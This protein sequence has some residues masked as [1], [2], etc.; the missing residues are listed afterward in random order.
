MRNRFVL[1]EVVRLDLSDGDWIE[2]KKRLTNGERRRLN[3]AALSKSVAIG[4]ESTNEVDI[5]FAEFGTARALAY[6]VDW[7]FRDAQGLRVEVTR[8]AYESLDEETSD[9]IDKAL[10]AHIEAQAGNSPT[11]SANGSGPASSSAS[12]SGGP[13]MTGSTRL[14]S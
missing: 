6:L 9:E 4:G 10:D 7:S 11:T 2:V 3:T 8:S 14:L 1:P 5:D 13:G 12:G